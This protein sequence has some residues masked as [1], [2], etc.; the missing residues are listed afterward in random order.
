MMRIKSQMQSLVNHQDAIVLK[1]SNIKD[2]S[3]RNQNAITDVYGASEESA[4]HIEEITSSMSDINQSIATLE[5]Q[6][7]LFRLKK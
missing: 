6:V 3:H 5:K 2:L 4:A 7:T 1:A